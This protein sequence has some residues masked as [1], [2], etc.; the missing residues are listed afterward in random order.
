MLQRSAAL[1]FISILLGRRDTMSAK[2]LMTGEPRTLFVL[3]L[4]TGASDIGSTVATCKKVCCVSGPRYNTGDLNDLFSMAFRYDM[5][6]VRSPLRTL[7]L[8]LMC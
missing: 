1:T 2:I 7:R 8:S 5:K 4:L 3:H 6:L